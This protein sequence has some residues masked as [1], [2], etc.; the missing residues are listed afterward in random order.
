MIIKMNTMTTMTIMI[1]MMTKR[2]FNISKGI[3]YLNPLCICVVCKGLRLYKHPSIIARFIFMSFQLSL[4]IFSFFYISI[5]P[6]IL[7]S[8]THLS[9]LSVF[10]S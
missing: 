5:C 7:I 6:F 9:I 3:V 2:I 10:Q 4:S 8:I 1:W